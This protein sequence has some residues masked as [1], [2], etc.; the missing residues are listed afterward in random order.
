[1]RD[2]RPRGQQRRRR[3]R[4][5]SG[6]RHPPQTHRQGHIVRHRRHA[7]CRR[8][9][10]QA[11]RETLRHPAAHGPRQ[12][13]ARPGLG[14][15]IRRRDLG[16]VLPPHD[17][18]AAVDQGAVRA[19]LHPRHEG[20]FTR[21]HEGRGGAEGEGVSG[22]R[23]HPRRGSKTFAAAAAAA[24]RGRRLVDGRSQE[25]P[26]EPAPEWVDPLPQ[27]PPTAQPAV[28]RGQVAKRRVI[29]I[30]DVHHH[31]GLHP[32][33]LAEDVDRDRVE[34]AA[35]HEEIAGFIVAHGG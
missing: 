12:L 2:N 23:R 20:R 27:E 22:I 35:V 17:G 31:H 34:V 13:G 18:Q 5:G 19:Q 30:L 15:T 9:P 28:V 21:R 26:P 32:H 33:A 1:M 6:R 10:P 4:R 16:R 25:P 8:L 14:P 24:A 3:R 7:L 29:V 11:H